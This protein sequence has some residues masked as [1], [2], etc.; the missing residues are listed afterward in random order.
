MNP[1][2]AGA[3]VVVVLRK[4]GMARLCV[5]NSDGVSVLSLVA[6]DAAAGTLP[7]TAAAVRTAAAAAS[8]AAAGCV[9]VTRQVWLRYVLVVACSS[10]R[11]CVRA[12]VR[13]MRA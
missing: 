12:C 4:P 3:T 1:L 6:E 13:G 8:A 2:L 9:A 7:L 5:V 11:A 10:S